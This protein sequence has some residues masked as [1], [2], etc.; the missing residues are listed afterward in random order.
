MS[1]CRKLPAAEVCGQ[2][3]HSL[4]TSV[5]PL[6]VLEPVV[7]HDLVD[8]FRGVAGELTQLGELSAQGSE[9]SAQNAGSLGLTFCR[10]RH[11]EIAHADFAQA[12]MQK[13]DNAA[14]PNREGPR[15]RARHQ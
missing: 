8:V 12:K 5:S 9:D 7:D 10:K 1:K 2:E 14:Q 4:A 6:V 11:G 3:Q 13:I 15:H